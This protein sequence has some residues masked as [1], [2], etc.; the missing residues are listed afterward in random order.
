VANDQR[1]MTPARATPAAQKNGLLS[2]TRRNVNV[3]IAAVGG[4]VITAGRRRLTEGDGA[5]MEVSRSTTT[6]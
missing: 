1:E 4:R 5:V 3:L 6:I 2:D